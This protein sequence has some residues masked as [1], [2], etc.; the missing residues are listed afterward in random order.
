MREVYEQWKEQNIL[1]L[2][3]C[4]VL[5]GCCCDMVMNMHTPPEYKSDGWR[6]S[7]YGELDQIFIQ[8]P[9]YVYEFFWNILMW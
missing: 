9:A 7:L 3:S 8:V 6:G 4:V 1:V 5:R 2:K